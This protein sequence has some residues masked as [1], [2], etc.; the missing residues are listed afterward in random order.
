MKHFLPFSMLLA[1]AAF[2]GS[3]FA[4]EDRPQL[5]PS[6]EHPNIILFLVDDMGWQ[7]TSVPFYKEETPLN[8]R[9]RTPNMEE[10]AKQGVKFMQA[11]ACAISSPTRCSLMSGMNAAR[12]RVTN[13]TLEYN[14]KT[15]AGS[16]V[17]NLPD[18][19]YNGIQPAAVATDHDLDNGTP[20]TSFPEIL[21]NAGYYT[22]HCGKAH[23]GSLTTS[24]A[25]PENFGFDVNIAGGA[26]GGPG[27]YLAENEYGS[28]SFH[29]SGLE[30]YYGTG[31]FLTEALTQEALKAIEK[32]INENRPFYL[33]M[34]H[35][36]I[37]SPYDPDTRY[38]GNYT[39]YFDEQLQA[40]L[41]TQEINHAALV[42]GM[43]KSLG[44]IM[45]YLKDHP[46]VAQNTVVLFM[47]DNG[48]Q[49]VSVRQ[50]RANY[51]QNWPA[52]GGKGSAYE[53]GVHEPMMLYWPGNTNIKQGSEN[54]SRIMIED[55]FPTILDLAG[56]KD[57][58]TVQKV[59]G[60][61]FADI[62]RDPTIERTRTNI[63]HFPN[64]WGESQNT[65]EGYGAYSAILKGDYRMIYFWESQERRLYNIKE[66][67]GETNNLAKAEPELLKE[68]SKELTDSLKAYDAQRPSYK[69][70]GEV[71]PWPDEA[72]TPVEVGEAV[73]V[74]AGIFKY[75]TEDVKYYYTISDNR[76]S[77]SGNKNFYWTL[78]EHNGYK[79]IQATQEQFANAY[80]ATKQYF[81]FMPGSDETHFTMYTVDGRKVNYVDGITGSSWN[82]GNVGSDVTTPYMQYETEEAG[83]FQLISIGSFGRY[84]I[85]APNGDLLNDRGT[86]NGSTAN[87]KWVI[88]TYSGFQLTDPGSQY[89]FTAVPGNSIS[90]LITELYNKYKENADYVGAHDISSVTPIYEEAMKDPDLED[91]K[92]LEDAY[93][94]TPT[95]EMEFGKIY[96]LRNYARKASTGNTSCNG[97]GG[98]LEP[99]DVNNPDHKE[100]TKVAFAAID[101]DQ[102]HANA[103]WRAEAAPAEGTFY[104]RN[105]NTGKYISATNAANGNTALSTDDISQAQVFKIVAYGDMQYKIALASNESVRLHVSGN[106]DGTKQTTR[107]MFYNAED[108]NTAS[109]WYLVYARDIDV[110]TKQSANGNF[111]STYLPIAVDMPEGL[112]AYTGK[113]EGETLKLTEVKGTVPAET[114]VVLKGENAQTYSLPIVD[115]EVA[116]LEGNELQGSLIYKATEGMPYFQLLVTEENA[117]YQ[118]VTSDYL[119]GNAAWLDGAGVTAPD[120]LTLDFGGQ[121]GIDQVEADKKD[122]KIYDLTGRRVKRPVKGI[123]IQ[124]GQK[125]IY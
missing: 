35:Y 60:K 48:G 118:S 71:I 22:I 65:A 61:S 83:E 43:D 87:M 42:E 15:D 7:E 116:A 25:D 92:A 59:D 91:L 12:H 99:I 17:I 54:H 29:V 113:V 107:L 88:N 33:Y 109:A 34:S 81:Y 72:P 32:P 115:Q 14:T 5:T 69:E 8:R 80:D 52:R 66:D 98:Y 40:N 45:Q 89:K 63:W 47:A 86:A 53:G 102:T 121:V 41:N 9:Y 19:N 11:Y 46:D 51:D 57:Y 62:L 122:S 90:G 94:K 44:D 93:A 39:N 124:N 20:I 112:T 31:T 24:G 125:V 95:L 97:A 30:D 123:Y 101:A 64:L 119:T 74:T 2:S 38:T 70:T 58:E 106:V 103:L 49:A 13:W 82:S 76:G 110:T 28:G 37:H 77:E 117:N 6:M 10:M 36:A 104:L 73:P 1:G 16:T 96:R 27:S 67:I 3:A 120:G 50:G 68:L 108:K 4:Q 79:A 85:K 84:A 26:N 18:W 111:A 55:F 105:V 100:S 21:Q 56:V 114:G 78:G 23:F 75:S